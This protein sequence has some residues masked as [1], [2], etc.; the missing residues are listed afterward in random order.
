MFAP[1]S[2][3]RPQEFSLGLATRDAMGFYCLLRVFFFFCWKPGTKKL[4]QPAAF[5]LRNQV[6]RI[7]TH[8]LYPSFVF[9]FAICHVPML[10]FC[11]V[12]SSVCS[13][14]LPRLQ[15]TFPDA[16]PPAAVEV[17]EKVLPP[18][19]ETE[20]DGDEEEPM[21]EVKYNSPSRCTLC[22][23]ISGH[24]EPRLVGS[25]GVGCR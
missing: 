21:L 6:V 18:R 14:R 23:L 9:V 13:S 7:N 20:Y 17:L 16:L 11:F 1:K 5:S 3:C 2:E 4:C 22:R 12:A 15:V 8:T 19:P 24:A 25:G 10:M